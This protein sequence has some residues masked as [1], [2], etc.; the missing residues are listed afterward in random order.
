MKKFAVAIVIVGLAAGAWLF[1][2]SRSAKDA[3]AQVAAPAA[4]PVV[5]GV[6]ELRDTPVYLAGLGTVQPLNSVLVRSRVDGQL[7]KLMF[8]E[9][10]EVHRGDAIAQLDPQPFEAQLRQAQASRTKDEAQLANARVDLERYTSSIHRGAVPQQL[11]D[12][13]KAQV[14]QLQAQVQ[15]DAAAID[16]A[17]IQ[18][19]YATI[20][21]P[22]DGRTGARL[23]DAGNLVRA[24]DSGGIVLINQIHPIT[25][26]FSLP[27]ESLGAIQ[28]HARD[29]ELAVIALRRDGS[30]VLGSGKL[31][32]IDNQIDPTTATIKLKATFSN[33]DDLLW[34]GQFVNARLIL[35]TRTNALTVPALA[36]QR[37]PDGVYAYVIKHDAGGDIIE[38]RALNIASTDDQRVVVDAGLSAGERV[39]LEGQYKLE[40]GSRVSVT[41]AAPAK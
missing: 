33:D 30:G 38:R 19:N 15:A 20:R 10:Q 6:A 16:N 37:G 3:V 24:N 13:A 35:Q 39:V 41:E 4:I 8:V 5:A 31:V 22:L 26:V 11:V 1:A 14:A 2:S 36:V 29:G 27:A 23:V 34:P 28:T 18:L 21:A 40:N 7:D 12:T 17:R 9:G 25:V 32:L